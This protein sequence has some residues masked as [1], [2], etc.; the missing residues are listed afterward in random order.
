MSGTFSAF[1]SMKAG[2]VC[3]LPLMECYKF[4]KGP[5]AFETDL[6]D[7]KTRVEEAKLAKALEKQLEKE[8]K[9]EAKKPA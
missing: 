7:A 6:S 4:L 3:T 8:S 9:L 5:K 1:G 2:Y